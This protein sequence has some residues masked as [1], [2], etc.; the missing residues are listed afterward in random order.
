MSGPAGLAIG[1]DGNL[2]ISSQN[3]DSIVEYNVGTST[4]STFINT[5]KLDAIVGPFGPA[6]L[7]FGPDGNLYVASSGGDVVRLNMT[8]VNGTLSY[9]GTNAIISTGL[10]DPTEMTF[11]TAAN[12]LDSLYVS[13]SGADTV[14]KIAHAGAANPT[15]TAFIT[16]GAN[17]LGTTTM[18]FPSGLTWQNGKLFVVDLGAHLEF[19][20]GAPLQRQR[21]F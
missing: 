17:G 10:A 11:G 18:N 3:N 15:T 1:P 19:R 8:N 2:Y 7:Q 20:P 16:P 4:L 13:N 12:D 6:G 5:T 14:V 21:F 9:T